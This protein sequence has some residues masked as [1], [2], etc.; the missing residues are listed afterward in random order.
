MSTQN[1]QTQT[2]DEIRAEIRAEIEAHEV[3]LAGHDKYVADC[4]AHPNAELVARFVSFLKTE[5]VR[6]IIIA[7]HEATIAELEAKIRVR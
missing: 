1:T 2:H 4:L 3:Y 6:E 5:K 7:N